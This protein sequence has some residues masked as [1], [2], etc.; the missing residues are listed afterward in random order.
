MGF[1]VSGLTEEECDQL[2][3]E[4]IEKENAERNKE[5]RNILKD[6]QNHYEQVQTYS[7]L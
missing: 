3:E 2:E 7:S 6:L 1:I 5:R 4:D